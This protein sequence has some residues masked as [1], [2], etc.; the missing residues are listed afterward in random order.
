MKKTYTKKSN[1]EKE[2]EVNELIEKA[3]KGIENCF[4]SPEQ[5]KELANYMGKFYKYSFRNTLLIQSQFL[6]AVA[7]GSYGFWK[8]KGFS[9]NKGEKGIKILV[10]NKLSDYFI[11][12]DG[13]EVKIKEM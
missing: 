8:E 13:K 6:G 12:A 7:V 10:P 11:N 4:T 9:V 5:I 1:E 3:N 2:K